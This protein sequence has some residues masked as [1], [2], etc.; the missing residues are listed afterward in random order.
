M[1]RK[2]LLNMSFDLEKKC[3]FSSNTFSRKIDKHVANQKKEIFN[4]MMQE[5]ILRSTVFITF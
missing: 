3:H 1:E 2:S 4:L 5:V